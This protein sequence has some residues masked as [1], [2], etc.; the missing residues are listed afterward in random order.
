[1]AAPL[2]IGLMS[3][4]SLDG[5]DAVAVRFEPRFELLGS[6]SMAL[7]K[8]IRQRI[9]T[10]CTSDTD[11]I[12]QM[13]IL[14]NHLAHLFAQAS[15][16]LIEQAGIAAADIAAIGSHGQTIRHRPEH[17]FTLQIGNPSLIAE[18]TGITTVADFR[19]RDMAA[20]G[21][22][23]PLVPAFHK[24]LF[25]DPHKNRVIANIGGMANI[26][27]LPAAATD[28]V[29]GFDTGPGNV[30]LD[31]WISRQLN[32]TYDADGQWAAG[33]QC[34]A[35]LLHQMLQLPYFSLQPPKSTGREQFNMDWLQQQLDTI[36]QPIPIADVQATLLELTARTLA[37]AVRV[38][39]PA[40]NGELFVCG[41]GSHNRTLMTRLTTLLAPLRVTT[42]SDLGL[43][44]DWVEAA[45]FAWLAHQTLHNRC[46]NLPAVTG[47][48]GERILGAIYPA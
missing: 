12:E 32:K 29:I 44:P 16:E 5:I 42:T 48:K 31:G 45:A 36:G 6:Y 47:A 18:L 26:T 21:Q 39:C 9:L 20:G 43:H 11:E 37:D 10:L 38:I 40:D 15:L 2:Y 8:E 19:R 34:H 35:G 33:G 4:T 17:G 27:F 7:P 41:G 24:A 3:G 22:G 1:M 30:L 28:R 23:A 46:G 25:S 13:G 14:D